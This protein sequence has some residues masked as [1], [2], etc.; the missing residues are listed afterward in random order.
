MTDDLAD[1]DT[2]DGGLSSRGRGRWWSDSAHR[3]KARSLDL[4][5]EGCVL[6]GPQLS[7]P[8]GR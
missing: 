5:A 8:S 7:M 4:G 6:D 3:D 2:P 1:T